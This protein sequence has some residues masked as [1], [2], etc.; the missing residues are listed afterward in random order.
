MFTSSFFFNAPFLVRSVEVL[1]S[2]E[3]G[4][5]VLV[6]GFLFSVHLFSSDVGFIL[7]DT[8]FLA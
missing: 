1:P 7:F 6:L 8:A 4:D 5:G 2:L 3:D